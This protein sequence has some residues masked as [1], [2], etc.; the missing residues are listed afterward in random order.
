MQGLDRQLY[1][2]C[3]SLQQSKWTVCSS[4]H[5]FHRLTTDEFCVQQLN[6]ITSKVFILHKHTTKV[7]KII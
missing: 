6:K 2:L 7:A 3:S 1:Q 4:L 5:S